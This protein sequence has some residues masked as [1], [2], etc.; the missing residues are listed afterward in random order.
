MPPPPDPAMLAAQHQAQLEAS[1][2]ALAADQSPRS[3][4]AHRARRQP[5]R[6]ILPAVGAAI[7]VLLVGVGIS[8]WFGSSSP[9]ASTLPP[10]THR[11]LVSTPPLSS[12]PTPKASATKAPTPRRTAKPAAPA[13]PPVV[14]APAVVLNETAVRG[15]AAHVAAVLRTKHW[16]VT[17]VGNWYGQIGSTTVYYPPGMEAAARSLAYDLG[18]SRI[19]PSARGMLNNRLTVVLTRNPL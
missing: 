5:A 17:G 16:V 10:V 15:L 8:G 1:A 3:G 18:V 9:T 4:G 6:Y 19:L 13:A 2:A 7:A 14:H 12:P 11:S